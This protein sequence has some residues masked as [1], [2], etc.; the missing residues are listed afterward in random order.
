MKRKT[1]KQIFIKRLILWIIG[2][3]IFLTVGTGVL[4]I[5]IYTMGE[6]AYYNYEG[7]VVNRLYS[8]YYDIQ[9][10]ELDREDTIKFLEQ[11]ISLILGMEYFPSTAA[12]V[13]DG[14]TGERLFDS[15]EKGL[16]ILLN[17][18]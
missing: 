10:K 7:T 15:R 5:Y 1:F 18:K 9:S 16:A 3:I 8:E 17:K 4:N 11:R 2:A 13:Y 14:D 6:G 12:V